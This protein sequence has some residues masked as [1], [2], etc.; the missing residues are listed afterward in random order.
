MHY[1]DTSVLI[2]ALTTEQSA[3]QVRQWLAT[4][5]DFFISPWVQTEFASSLSL[6]RRAGDIDDRGRAVARTGF[7]R[8]QKDSLA[9]LPIE[10]KHF[11]SAEALCHA[12]AGLRSSEALHLAVARDNGLTMVSRDARFVAAT[13]SIGLRAVNP[14]EAA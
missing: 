6:K 4:H 8:L 13:R 12:D 10:P 9:T 5:H 7:E 11:A 3:T 2:S 1:L 14:D